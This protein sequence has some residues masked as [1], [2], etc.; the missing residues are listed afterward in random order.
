MAKRVGYQTV[1]TSWNAV[2]CKL[3]SNILNFIFSITL[4]ENINIISFNSKEF[5]VRLYEYVNKL[6]QSL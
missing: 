6:C 1:F 3:C 4:T 2:K 5:K